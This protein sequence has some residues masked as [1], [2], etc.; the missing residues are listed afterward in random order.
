MTEQAGEGEG[1]GEG[2]EEMAGEIEIPE[3]PA[4]I[5]KVDGFLQGTEAEDL[6]IGQRI[7]PAPTPSSNSLHTRLEHGA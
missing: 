5:R 2:E 7:G 3:K 4:H 1:E 6:R